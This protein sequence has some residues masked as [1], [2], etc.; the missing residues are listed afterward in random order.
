MT[1]RQ[2][3]V[4]DVLLDKVAQEGIQVRWGKKVAGIEEGAD[5]AT[6]MFEDGTSDMADL[7]L[8]CDGIDSVLRTLYVAPEVVPQYS[9]LSKI[10]AFLSVKK[11]PEFSTSVTCAHA[12]FTQDGL[13]GIMPC[14]KAG[15]TLY[16]FFTHEV[17][18]PTTGGSR[19]EWDEHR[20]TEVEGFKTKIFARLRDAQGRWGSLFKNAVL[21]T[22]KVSFDP[23]FSLPLGTKWF[24]GRCLL[25]GDAAHAM[26]P[27]T[28]QGISMAL[29]DV[30]LLSRL[31]K[32]TYASLSDV[33]EK[34]DELRRPRVEKMYTY[35][36]RQ[37][38]Q[39][40]KL[41]PWVRIFRESVWWLGL[42]VVM[43]L[44]LHSWTLG[45]ENLVYDIDE[46]DI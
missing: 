21:Q 44:N 19:D 25:V 13:F 40:R 36:A 7:V 37:G 18:V 17:P 39:R 8:G 38:D 35:E 16:W 26:Q 1:A 42:T 31:L 24:R 45:P 22:E 34:F 20:Q 5:G 2:T 23:I 32:T 14:T 11:L 15:D 6:V 3:D 46:V 4:A 41:G 12:M 29:E 30:F 9:G 28:R 43:K 33:F 27:H 10:F